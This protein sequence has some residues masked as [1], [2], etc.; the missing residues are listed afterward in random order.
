MLGRGWGKIA[1]LLAPTCQL[2]SATLTVL[3]LRRGQCVQI[4]AE[5]ETIMTTLSHEA[6]SGARGKEGRAGPTPRPGADWRCR[7]K[8]GCTVYDASRTI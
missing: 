8:S 2:R 1:R 3:A 6:D 5:V 7:L 4:V